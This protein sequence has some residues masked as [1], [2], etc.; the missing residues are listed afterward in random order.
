VISRYK[1]DCSLNKCG[2]LGSYSITSLDEN[3]NIVGATTSN[4]PIDCVYGEVIEFHLD[5]ETVS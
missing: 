5:E 3:L 4:R 2:N 1:V